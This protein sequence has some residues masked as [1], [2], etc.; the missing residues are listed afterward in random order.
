MQPRYKKMFLWLLLALVPA[1]AAVLA[2][3]NPG[4]VAQTR[5]DHPD[6][7]LRTRRY[8]RRGDPAALRRA[9]EESMLGLSTYGRS[10]RVVGTTPAAEASGGFTIRAEVPVLLYTD[11]LA[12]QVRPDLTKGWWLVDVTSRSRVGKS[13]L[14]ENRRHVVQLLRL[15]DEQLGD[16]GRYKN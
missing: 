16:Q 8:P 7:A 2:I 4:N 5:P 1:A 11:D 13:D 9:I 12:V 3:R 15:L 14:G 10:W 6:P